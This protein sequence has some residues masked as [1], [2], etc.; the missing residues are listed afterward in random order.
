ETTLRV[1]LLFRGPG[2]VPGTQVQGTARSID[3]LPTVL[4]LLGVAAPARLPGRS[5]AAVLRGGPQLP[6]TPAYA[7]SLTPRLHYGWSDLR[8]LREGRWKYILAPRPELYDLQEDPGET[9]N[10]A[11]GPS[12]RADAL[13]A[14]LVGLVARERAAPS[15]DA[16]GAI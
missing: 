4:D 16:A 11:I 10:L 13:R 14:Q 5:L 2:I 8:A 3:L 12:A 9:R 7:E 1:P 15:P 6:D